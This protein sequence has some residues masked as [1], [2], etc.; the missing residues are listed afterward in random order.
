M[1]EDL[2]NDHYIHLSLN[3]NDYFN[4]S[5]DFIVTLIGANGDQV[6]PEGEVVLIDSSIGAISK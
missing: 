6:I 5:D 4:E 1:P 2:N 3:K